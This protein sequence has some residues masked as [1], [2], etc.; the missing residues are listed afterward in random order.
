MELSLGVLVRAF[1]AELDSEMGANSETP[2]EEAE[3]YG[4]GADDEAPP[5]DSA[6]LEGGTEDPSRNHRGWEPQLSY[7]QRC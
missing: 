5:E 3:M 1:E 4:L 2:E 7:I 6:A